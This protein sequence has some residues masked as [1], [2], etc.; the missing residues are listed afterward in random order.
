M[1]ALSRPIVGDAETEALARVLRSGRLA[2]G[3]EVEAFEVE[4]A[5]HAEA[6][7]AIA[8]SNGTTALEIGLRALGIGR[9]DEVVVPSFTFMATA[10][11]VAMIG[12]Q[13]VF[14][15]IDPASYCITADAVEAVVSPRTAA[16]IAVHLYGHPAPLDQLLELCDRRGIAL[17]EDAAQGAG[18][19][20]KGRHVGAHGAFGTFSFYPTKN[21]TTAEGGMITTD[22]AEIAHRVAQLRNHGMRERYV[23][24]IIGTNARMSELSAAIG[25]VQLRRLPGWVAERRRNAEHYDLA[26][27][28]YVGVPE[29]M[30]GATHAYHQYTLRTPRREQLAASLHRDGIGF[31]LFYATPCHAQAPYHDMAGDLPET[32]HAAREVLSIPVRPDLTDDDLRS[33]VEAVRSGVTT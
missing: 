15:D 9:G 11:A 24:E 22:D 19:A 18:A 25:R 12:A 31:G 13:P 20:W 6:C 21:M 23:H 26:L 14:A 30:D 5:R 8:V 3:P 7:H 33:V 32:D 2:A 10:N 28:G 27:D 16:V 4:F 29:I 1:I 17:I